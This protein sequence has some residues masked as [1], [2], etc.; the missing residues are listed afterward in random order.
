MESLPLH[1]KKLFKELHRGTSVEEALK[2]LVPYLNRDMSL[3]SILTS[4][5]LSIETNEF[6]RSPSYS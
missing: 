6:S 1:I 5:G 4:C 2:A 3:Y